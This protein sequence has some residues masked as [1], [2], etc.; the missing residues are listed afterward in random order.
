M[1]FKADALCLK[2]VDYKEKDKLLTLIS[3]RNGKFTCLA[4][5]VRAQNAKLKLAASPLCFGEYIILSKGNILTGCQVYDNFFNIWE[6]AG[7][8]KAAFAILE[9]LEKICPEQ[10]PAAAELVR[11]LNALK[12]ICYAPAYPLAYLAWFLAGILNTLGADCAGYNIKEQTL[13]FI[14]SLDCMPMEA[15]ESLDEDESKINGV[16]GILIRVLNHFS[17]LSFPVLH[18]VIKN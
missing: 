16:L 15:V 10:E 13:D 8:A 5:G 9:V 12:G 6:D 18:S 2:A 1:Y 14:S 11:A 3:A 7:R 17:A 4:R